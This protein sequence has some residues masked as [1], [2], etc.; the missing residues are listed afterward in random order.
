MLQQVLEYLGRY[1][2]CKPYRG[3][4]RIQDGLLS[5]GDGQNAQ[6]FDWQAFAA[7]FPWDPIHIGEPIS[8]SSQF[9]LME[10]QRFL[11]YGSVFNDGVYTFHESGITNDDDNAAAGLTDETFTGAICALAVPP[12]V[13]ALS[14]EI[15]QWVAKYSEAVDS[16][17]QSESF[18][19]YSYH[20]KSGS[21]AGGAGQLSWQD[22][23]A[24]R[25]NQWRRPFV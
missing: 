23:F 19:G 3:S 15:N 11:V 13:I 16:P 12:A 25:L 6:A 21:G 22:I 18:N 9:Q 20:L 8:M 1:F 5:I 24:A 7:S 17:Y 14:A 4:Y 10:G 2:V